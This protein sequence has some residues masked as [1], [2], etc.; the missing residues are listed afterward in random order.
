MTKRRRKDLPKLPST[1]VEFTELLPDSPLSG[2][3]RFT[4]REGNE[5]A[6]V[7]ATDLLISKL[8]LIETIHFY[9][10]LKVVPHL[11]I[12]YSQSL[13]SIKVMLCQQC[14]SY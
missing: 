9:G 4:V 11:F 14:I 10:T 5:A 13:F 3:H 2:N 7:F 8:P 1:C 12:S 6:L